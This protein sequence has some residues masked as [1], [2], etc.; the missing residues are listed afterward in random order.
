MF[1]AVLVFL[2][3]LAWSQTTV[4]GY[5]TDVLCGKAGYPEG[6]KGKIDLTLTPEKNIVGCLIME[7]CKD[8]GYGLNIMGSTGK[9]IF[10]SFDATSNAKIVREVLPLLTKPGN[11]APLVR[12]S[13]TINAKGV[14]SA[15]SKVEI[16]VK[17]TV[18]TVPVPTSSMGMHNM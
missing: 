7:N 12:V 13:G 17:T 5:L 1:A 9:Y 14:I 11:P 3:S 8:S 15:V 16:V 4:E 10:H 2:G 18:K 6:Y